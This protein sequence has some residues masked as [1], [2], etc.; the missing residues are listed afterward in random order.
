M[1]DGSTK[2]RGE[3]GLC[4]SAPL[5]PFTYVP[6]Q[7][8]S[9]DIHFT[10]LPP[11]AGHFFPSGAVPVPLHVKH[12]TSAPPQAPSHAHHNTYTCSPAYPVSRSHGNSRT[13]PTRPAAPTPAGHTPHTTNTHSPETSATYQ[14]PRTAGTPSPCFAPA[15]S[16]RAHVT[17][18][19][20]IRLRH[21]FQIV[22]HQRPATHRVK[23]SRADPRFRVHKVGHRRGLLH[24]IRAVPN[25]SDKVLPRRFCH[26]GEPTTPRSN[27]TPS[28]TRTVQHHVVIS[29]P[30]RSTGKGNRWSNSKI[31][32]ELE[33]AIFTHRLVATASW[34][35]AN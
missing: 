20:G 1:S 18:R 4:G 26:A 31:P 5:S 29:E 27:L 35:M 15:R 3:S 25:Q 28:V 22:L 33:N 6:Q 2:K 7:N 13:P 23:P 16:G 24:S 30:A 8:S 32:K 10:P 9:P 21:L 17:H 19:P 11:H 12:R 14:S 34:F